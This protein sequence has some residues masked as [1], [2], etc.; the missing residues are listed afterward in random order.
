MGSNLAIFHIGPVQDFIRSARR[1]RDLWYGS[2][3][4]SELAKAAAI[5]IEELSPK[6]LI[7]PNTD[8][9]E[10]QEAPSFPNRILANIHIPIEKAGKEVKDAISKR[11]EDL[12]KDAFK[13]ISG[14]FD[15]ELAIKQC[16]E[17]LEYF[18]AS[19]PLKSETE[20]FLRRNQAEYFLAAR[21][22]TR[23]FEQTIGS[24]SPKSSLDGA[25]ESVIL[26]DKY[27]GREDPDRARKVQD[28]YRHYRAGPGERLSGVDLLKRLGETLSAPK[29]FSTSQMAALPFMEKIGEKRTK[30]LVGNIRALLQAKS[31]E[32]ADESDDGALLFENRLVDWVP[33]E[34]EREEA[35]KQFTEIM[36]KHV[37]S[38]RPN[39][40]YALL[41]ADGDNIGV[42]VDGQ[43]TKKAHQNLS[44][45]MSKFAIR[46]PK[47]I[48]KHKGVAIYSGGDDVLAY[49][50][51]HTVLVCAN[52]LEEEFRR[53]LK[54]F[55]VSRDGVAFS[56]TLSAGIVIAHHLE[57]LSDV[58]Q[59]AREAEKKAKKLDGKNGLEIVLIRRSGVERKIIGKWGEVAG[60]IQRLIEFAKE[61]VIS[62]GSAYELHD[63]GRI[64]EG[65][66]PNK[67]IV[68]EAE[69][70]VMRKQESGGEKPV[71]GQVIR[72][73]GE[74]LKQVDVS[75]L[76][77]EMI[78]ARAFVDQSEMQET[79]PS[80]DALPA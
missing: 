39:P 79:N 59:S 36:E 68:A 2:W 16:E 34:R 57:P 25:R 19:V 22:A 18:W 23:D 29:F 7:F 48:E 53:E 54:D 14:E 33:D 20:Y 40:Y 28:L 38:T 32:D 66:V 49:L 71:S 76:S 77:T 24:N 45:A 72:E 46:A 42:V 50:P 15:Q 74:W 13:S 3:L 44:K 26:E 73:F 8:L 5:K 9:L 51:L 69:R 27:P 55:G 30:A 64:L 10:S 78:V 31:L 63:L 56:P 41:A 70:I 80:V 67:S 35:R 58:L 6:S 62:S 60:R 61:G 75:Q 52:E 12:Y 65:V 11:L 17:T 21:K 4:L 47:I 43:E 1:S 37:G